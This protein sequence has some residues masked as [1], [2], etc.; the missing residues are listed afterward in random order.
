MNFY[1]LKS[2]FF[3]IFSCFILQTAA[4]AQNNVKITIKKK[5][6]TLQEALREV[7]KQSDYLI[8]FNESKLEKT[9]RVNLNINAESLDKTLAVRNGAFL[10]NQ[11]QIYHDY[12][13]IK[14]GSRKQKTVGDSER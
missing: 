4:F 3:I 6:I 2:I 10:Q 1:R 5:N 14:S 13:A 11:R 7:E 9:K 8:A 12:S